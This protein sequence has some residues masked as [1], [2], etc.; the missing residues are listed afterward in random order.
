MNADAY[1]HKVNTVLK[2]LMK[3]NA[4]SAYYIFQ[5]AST[6]AQNL[7]KTQQWLEENFK[8]FWPK[9]LWPPSLQN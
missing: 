5:L 3:I 4:G 7:N 9:V 1:I 8:A 2:P 6:L